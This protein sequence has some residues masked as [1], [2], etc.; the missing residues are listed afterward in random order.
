[1]SVKVTRIRQPSQS[2]KVKLQVDGVLSPAFLGLPS[3]AMCFVVIDHC[4]YITHCK[5]IV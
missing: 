3:G 1:M 4:V 5:I 2:N